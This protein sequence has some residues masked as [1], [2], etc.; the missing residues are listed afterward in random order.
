MVARRTSR[1]RG[2]RPQTDW[3]SLT[4][5]FSANIGFGTKILI[6]S[7]VG[8][9][10]V[11]IR[12]TFGLV[13]WRSDQQAVSEEPM[14][15]FGMCVVSED[16]FAAGAAAIPGPF[17]DADSDLWFVHQFMYSSFQ[18]ADA[19]GR[20]NPTGMQYQINSKAMRKL[21]EEERVV[22]MTENGHG[23]QGALSWMSLR[24]L[25]SLAG[26]S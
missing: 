1:T 25:S 3:A 9:G 14:G 13:S 4:A 11:T 23:S 20:T 16:A 5:P 12:R 26:R 6:G 22:V 10:P 7:F 8:T 21:T 19:T 18:F 15:A 24:V 2:F 17:S